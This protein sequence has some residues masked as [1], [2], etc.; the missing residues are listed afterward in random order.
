MEMFPCVEKSLEKCFE[1]NSSS[2]GSV[3][4]TG[5]TSLYALCL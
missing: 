4:K 5:N 2:T 3:A 1:N